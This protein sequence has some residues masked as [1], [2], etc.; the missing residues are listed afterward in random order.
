L[1]S[2]E[3]GSRDGGRDPAAADAVRTRWGW[4]EPRRER[5]ARGPGGPPSVAATPIAFIPGGP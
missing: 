4:R 2:G 1:P 3:S 5:G